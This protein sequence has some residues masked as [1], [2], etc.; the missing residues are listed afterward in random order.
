MDLRPVQQDLR[1]YSPSHVEG[2]PLLETSGDCCTGPYHTTLV[3]VPAFHSTSTS[4]TAPLSRTTQACR[5][6]R[7]R[8]GHAEI[9]VG[10]LLSLWP[11]S[12]GRV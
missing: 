7:C 8:D 10:Q 12:L 1:R 5:S 6:F 11:A 2:M 9:R 4:K 3:R